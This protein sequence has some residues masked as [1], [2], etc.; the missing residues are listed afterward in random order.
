LQG[1]FGV[2]TAARDPREIQYGLRIEF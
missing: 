1:D 2:N